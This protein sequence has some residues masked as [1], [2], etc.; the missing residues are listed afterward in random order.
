MNGGTGQGPKRVAWL[1]VIMH[2]VLPAL[3]AVGHAHAVDHGHHAQEHV[4]CPLCT[5]ADDPDALPD[6]AMVMVPVPRPGTI[7]VNDGAVA[8]LC[9]HGR[10]HGRGPPSC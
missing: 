6:P 9:L 7:S 10:E 5:W 3:H 8:I 1:I 4:S 2:L